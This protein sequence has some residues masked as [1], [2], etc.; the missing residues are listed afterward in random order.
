MGDCTADFV[1]IGE[2]PMWLAVNEAQG[3]ELPEE[4]EGVGARQRDLLLLGEA[5]ELALNGCPGQEESPCLVA[6]PEQRMDIPEVLLDFGS[7]QQWKLLSWKKLFRRAGGNQHEIPTRLLFDPLRKTADSVG[8]CFGAGR[9]QLDDQPLVSSICDQI[10]PIISEKRRESG[11]RGL[12]ENVVP[13]GSILFGDP[14]NSLPLADQR[15]R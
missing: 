3:D 13:L 1:S 14:L 6:R 5:P 15:I 8:L 4:S 12:D 9:L 11:T 10:G 2:H 7:A